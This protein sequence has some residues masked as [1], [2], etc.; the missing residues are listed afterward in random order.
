MLLNLT[1]RTCKLEKLFAD[2]IP[3]FSSITAVI[4]SQYF[5]LNDEI[6]Q[7]EASISD[8]I[9]WKIPSVK[10]VFDSAKVAL[11]SSYPLTEPTTSFSSPTFRTHLMDTFFSLN[12]I[13]MV[14]GPQLA[15][16]HHFYSSSSLVTATICFIGPSRR[17]STLVSVMNW[18]H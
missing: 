6:R 13:L 14:L 11:P 12:F 7:Q 16:V 15:N 3:A 9:I 8:A 4:H 18:T 5:F 10:F 2:E 17:S 1:S